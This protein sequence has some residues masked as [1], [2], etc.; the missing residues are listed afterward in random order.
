[1]SSGSPIEVLVL[2]SEYEWDDDDYATLTAA[3]REAHLVAAIVDKLKSPP[4]APERWLT[5]GNY[6]GVDAM[7]DS[8]AALIAQYAGRG[9]D[10]G[11]AV[12]LC[13]PTQIGCDP[14]CQ[15][16][17]W[18]DADEAAE[19]PPGAW[20][21]IVNLANIAAVPVIRGDRF[22]WAA[23][24]WHDHNPGPGGDPLLPGISDAAGARVCGCGAWNC[25]GAREIGDMF[26][27]LTLEPIVGDDPAP[28]AWATSSDA[29]AE[30]HTAWFAAGEDARRAIEDLQD[31][32][33]S[34][35]HLGCDMGPP[36]QWTTFLPIP[37]VSVGID[38]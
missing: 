8:R 20:Q 27:E 6:G 10:F 35:W 12:A 15:G 22:G 5:V 28:V 3:E 2:R 18:F 11:H 9:S 37:A 1:M 33:N 38:I 14:G 34:E 26:A 24:G 19:T 31:D 30:I 32:P 25:G 23:V 29:L 4:K 13:P 17:C 36:D 21:H 16:Q 7:A